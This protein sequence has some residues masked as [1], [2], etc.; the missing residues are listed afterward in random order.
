M[1]DLEKI[2]ALQKVASILGCSHKTDARLTRCVQE[3][4]PYATTPNANER[5]F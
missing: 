4:I 5:R 3:L 1:D 2:V